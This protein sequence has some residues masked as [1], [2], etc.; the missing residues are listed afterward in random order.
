MTNQ[1]TATKQ[2]PEGTRQ[3]AQQFEP[4]NTE[5]P[6]ASIREVLRN[7]NFVK[8][9]SAQ[10]LSQTAQQIVN[11]A[12][13]LQVANI[14]ASSTAVSG[15]I[16]SFTVPAILFAAIAGVF[17]ERNSKKTM[18]VLTNLAR[19]AMVLVY[20]AINPDWGAGV[21]LPM[22]YIVT[23]LFA[24]VSQFFNPAEASMIPLVVSKRELVSAN[25]L[26]NLTLPATQ[27]GGFI[28][29]GP[30]LL[31][32]LF[33][34]NYNGLYLTIFLLCLAAAAMTS[35]LPQDRP[36]ATA[37]ELRR[38]GEKVGVT[39]VAAGATEI[40]RSGYRQAGEELAEGWSFIRRD[41]VIMSAIIYWS[42]AIA[43]FM[44]L[45]TI[46]PTF[47]RMIGIDQ[48]KLF[49][50]LLPGGLGLVAGVL[51]VG[52]VSRPDNREAMI[53]VSLLAAGT[54][55]VF[56]A[57][58]YPIVNWIF[59]TTGRGAP[60]ENLILALLGLMALLL[61]FFN[62][63]ISVPAQT[64]LQERSPEQIRARVFSAFFTIS[65]AILVVP[66]FFAAALGDWFGYEQA[67]FGIG[68]IVILIAGL[69]LYRSRDRRTVAH[70]LRAAG[71][72]GASAGA[73][74]KYVTPEEAEAALT[75]VTPAPRPILAREQQ[76]MMDD[77]G[78]A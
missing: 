22:F 49:Y 36:E 19:G 77:E 52:R 8:L 34:N 30:L 58:L 78:S 6:G 46:G 5:D 35:L 15:I 20:L 50:I 32:T 31:S 63:F 43:V 75:S 2:R 28:I 68:V 54:T 62:S 18:L 33:H 39:Q 69:G 59:T 67:I 47:L 3:P 16:I 13:L 9:W 7:P 17:V 38:R 57:L 45:G 61:G 51:I 1:L 55:L 11:Y 66:V 21:V 65:N 29:L 56:F 40:A 73:A 23:L 37:S 44:M 26:F 24:A 70:Q 41:P 71:M 4:W 42:I 48:A 53:N 64:A 10:I 72:N 60:P 74:N 27:L 14:T 12:L 25:A 76:G